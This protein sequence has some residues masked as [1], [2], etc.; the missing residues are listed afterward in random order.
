MFARAALIARARLAAARQPAAAQAKRSMG[1]SSG[2]PPGGYTGFE[3]KI[4]AVCPEDKHVVMGVLGTYF[5]IYMLIKMITGGGGAEEAA[6]V[7]VAVVDDGS[8]SDIPSALSP[9]FEEWS[10]QPGNMKKWEDS[11]VD[12]V[13]DAKWEASISA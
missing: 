6:P 7:H 5:G 1:G 8:S 4:R 12:F 11:L 9:K 3:A 13:P 10:K 2:P